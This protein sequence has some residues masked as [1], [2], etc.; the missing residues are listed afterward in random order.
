MFPSKIDKIYD[1]MFSITTFEVHSFKLHSQKGL[2]SLDKLRSSITAAECGL[3]VSK[4]V[5]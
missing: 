5:N 3:L 1:K 4:T 2:A